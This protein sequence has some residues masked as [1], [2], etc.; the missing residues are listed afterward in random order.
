MRKIR[1]PTPPRKSKIYPSDPPWKK[2]WRRPCSRPLLLR[3]K[4]FSVVHVVTRTQLLETTA[5]AWRR[6]TSQASTGELKCWWRVPRCAFF[7]VR[8]D[9]V[10]ALEYRLCFD[11]VFVFV[12]VNARQTTKDV[13]EAS[14]K[15]RVHPAVHH[16]I[17]AA[18]THGQPVARDPH[19]LDVLVRVDGRV[20]VTDERDA[21]KRQPA[22]CVYDHHCYH[23]LHHLK[24]ATPS[25][26]Q[27][28]GL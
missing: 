14:S 12:V 3:D 10:V 9:T 20:S 2:S 4:L 24:S 27:S 16:G 8:Y 7:C 28:F 17:V 25:I 1:S 5:A 22:Q 18:V 13:C 6:A 19:S 11:A 15:A 26:K 23:H 21:V